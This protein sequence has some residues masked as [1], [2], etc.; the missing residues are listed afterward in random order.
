MLDQAG[1]LT[2]GPDAPHTPEDASGADARALASVPPEPID[3]ET[4]RE[5]LPYLRNSKKF[6]P[7]TR[8][9]KAKRRLAQRVEALG[10]RY[11]VWRLDA[12]RW[13]DRLDLAPDLAEEIGS[14]R[15]LRG[16]GTMVGLGAFAL[17]FWPDLT[18]LEA[19]AA[20]PQ[21]EDVQS[22]LRSQMILP[23]ALGA[24]SGRRMGPTPAVIP[25]KSAPERPQIAMVV[26]LAPGDSFATML[27]RAGVAGEDIDRAAALVGQAVAV[28]D[29]AP[30][31]QMDVLLGRRTAPGQPRPLDSLSFRARF[32][33]ELELTRPGVGMVGADG[34]P[35]VPSGPLA[36]KRN[37]IRVDETPLRVRGVVGSSL[38]RSMRQAGVPASAVQEYLKAL[39][40]QIDMDR[41][42]S[43]SD[44]FDIIIAYRRAATGERQ[45]GQLLYAG[46]DRGGKPR[47]QLMRWGSEGRFYEAS[48]VGE[49]RRGLLAPV[50]GPVTSNFGMRRHPILGYTRMHAGIDFKARYGTPIVAV[51]DGRVSAAGRAGGCG[52]AVRLEHGGGLSTRYC[53]MSQMAVRAGQQVRRGQVIG[54]VGSTGLS[55][56]AHLHYEMYRGG[57]AINPASVAFVSR[58]ELSGTELIDFRRQLIRLKEIEVGAAL[59]DLAPLP[60][61]TKEPLREIEKVETA[62][63]RRTGTTL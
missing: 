27:R 32:D 63:L 39:D 5:L 2:D 51:S 37:I 4:A 34:S 62:G 28:G 60:G 47:T 9:Q 56:G 31:T 15:W 44:E 21:G 10:A 46:I 18:P 12:S 35:V 22:E 1:K 54:Y 52:I 55:T 40:A 38:Y 19:R 25:L 29:I 20:M 30:G 17:A 26:T 57:R 11:E 6:A 23:L 53:H 49:Q 14:R 24:D 50:P 36:L 42:V 41:E 33:L 13:F 48:G 7:P 59:K 43:A 45:A 3:A 8:T 58:A 16:L 61:E